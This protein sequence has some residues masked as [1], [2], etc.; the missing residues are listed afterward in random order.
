MVRHERPEL[1]EQR[2]RLIVSIA[3][4]KHQLQD[5]EVRGGC[6]DKGGKG[7][8]L[9]CSLR[10]TEQPRCAAQDKILRLLREAE[11]NI[12]DDEQ[13]LATLNHSKRT[14]AAIQVCVWGMWTAGGWS[15]LR[16]PTQGTVG[17]A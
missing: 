15:R 6:A 16:R 11:G 14:S 5:L 3:A 2:D 9:M 10:S 7:S 8:G 13:L 12:L 1:E 4:D 17:A